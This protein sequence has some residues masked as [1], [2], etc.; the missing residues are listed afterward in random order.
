[1][2]CKEAY[3]P[4]SSGNNISKA[5]NVSNTRELGGPQSSESLPLPINSQYLED[6]KL[7]R[8]KLLSISHSNTNGITMEKEPNIIPDFIFCG[9]PRFLNRM[10]SSLEETAC[11]EKAFF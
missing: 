3:R 9:Q 2:Y 4:I 1:M 6:W 10:P 11:F 8:N 5:H 7:E